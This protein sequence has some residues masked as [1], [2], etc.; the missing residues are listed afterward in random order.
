MSDSP[1]E[2]LERW[3]HSGGTWRIA[4]LSGEGA[5]IDL[6]SCTGETQDVLRSTDPEFLA[7]L[8]ERLHS[9]SPRSSGGADD[10]DHA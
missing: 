3:E 5:V 2:I 8:D 7:L 10:G 4:S 6:C 9:H 1:I